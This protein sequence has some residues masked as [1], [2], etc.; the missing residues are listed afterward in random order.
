MGALNAFIT[1]TIKWF[2]IIAGLATCATLPF[3]IDINLFTPMLAVSSTIRLPVCP[4]CG[5]GDHGLR[6][7][8]IDGRR[9]VPSRATARC[10]TDAS[11]TVEKC[12]SSIALS[13]ISPALVMAISAGSWSTT[14]DPL[15]GI[16]YSERS[17]GPAEWVVKKSADPVFTTHSPP[18]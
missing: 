8:R 11:A 15:I 4:P 3:A 12:I 9:G 1:R 17:T 7:R 13:K 16:A 18:T 6:A 5:I 10:E 2:L 14:M